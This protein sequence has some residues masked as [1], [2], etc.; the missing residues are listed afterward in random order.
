M[1]SKEYQKLKEKIKKENQSMIHPSYTELIE[2]INAN[3][4]DDDTTMSLNSRYSLVLATSKRARQL[5]A[6]AKPMVEGAAGKKPLAIAIDELY[7]GKVKILAPE[8]ETEEE[9]AA[10]AEAAPAEEAAAE[11]TTETTEE[12]APAEETTE[13]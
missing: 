4:E 2:A 9:T 13:E 11:K 3:S 6:G 1:A 7:K 8:E 5:I 12:A 10:A